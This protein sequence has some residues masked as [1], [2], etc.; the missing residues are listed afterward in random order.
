MKGYLAVKG[1]HAAE[2]RIGSV[3]RTMH[4]PY[5]EA[6]RQV[7]YYT[8]QIQDDSGSAVVTCVLH[9]NHHH[10][11]HIHTYIP[12]IRMYLFSTKLLRNQF[13]DQRI[14]IYVL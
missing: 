1:V 14:I 11:N 7:G 9:V 3:L 6:R 4:Q 8:W 2:T 10:D 12:D 13:M 5:H